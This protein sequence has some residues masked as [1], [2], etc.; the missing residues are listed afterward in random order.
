ML[1]KKRFVRLL[2]KLN[3]RLHDMKGDTFL[4]RT[5]FGRGKPTR[6]SIFQKFHFVT[7]AQSDNVS[8]NWLLFYGI[9]TRTRLFVFSRKFPRFFL[10]LLQPK[11]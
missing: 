11:N 9:R 5:F 4:R 8:W 1:K 6:L 2:G 10:G 7:Y 3:F